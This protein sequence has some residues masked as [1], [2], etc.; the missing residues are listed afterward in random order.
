MIFQKIALLA[1]LLL[2]ACAT[3]L[4]AVRVKATDR[5]SLAQLGVQPGQPLI[6][7]F[8]EGDVIP[9]RVTVGGPLAESDPTTPPVV[10]RARRH[11]FLKLEGQSF[12][13]SLDGEHFDPPTSAPG[14]FAFG[15]GVDASGPQ[16]TVSVVTPSYR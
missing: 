2:V 9:L 7:E 5:A 3:P 8:D 16:A 6:V 4:P 10:V 14:T 1:P 15:L 12:K 11:F 13:I